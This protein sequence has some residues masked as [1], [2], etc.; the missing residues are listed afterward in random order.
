MAVTI[1]ARIPTETAEEL[2]ELA[3]EEERTV[4]EIVNRAIQ[5]YVRCARFPGIIF[6]TGGNGR[7]KAKLSGGPAVWS[8]V[9]T[10]RNHDMDVEKTADYLQIPVSSVRLALAYYAEYPGETDA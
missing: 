4:S 5:E 7:R 10:A 6:V 9:F 8:V 3:R 2:R 1:S